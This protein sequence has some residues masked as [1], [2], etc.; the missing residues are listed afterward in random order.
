MTTNTLCP[1]LMEN[2]RFLLE[3]ILPVPTEMSEDYF[4][5]AEKDTPEKLPDESSPF[6]SILELSTF[7]P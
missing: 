4:P 7:A 3:M 6:E 2:K 5:L 1:L